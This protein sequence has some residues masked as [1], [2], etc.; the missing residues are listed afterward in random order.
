[1]SEYNFFFFLNYSDSNERLAAA[2]TAV[3]AESAL[4]R[5]GRNSSFTSQKRPS[6]TFA[7]ESNSDA[8]KTKSI[9]KF[10]T[11]NVDGLNEKNLVLRT[12]AVCKTIL[13]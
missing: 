10:I 3:L 9:L 13:R 11:W 7:E 5:S 8:K 1:M 2:A 4:C 6:T 12:K